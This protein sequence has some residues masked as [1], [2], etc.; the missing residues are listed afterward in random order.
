MT[1]SS[2]PGDP[3]P[4]GRATSGRAAAS[5]RPEGRAEGRR[6][7]SG[8]ATVPGSLGD[9][10]GADS[11]EA[12]RR[13]GRRPGSRTSDAG[14]L[15][16]RDADGGYGD[17]GYGA[18]GRRAG[19]PDGGYGR[20][21]A[22][23]GPDRAGGASRDG[24]RRPGWGRILGILAL[25][26]VVLAG[27]VVVGAGIW[28]VRLD[29]KVDRIPG[30]FDGLADR[31][32]ASADGV[33][34]IL[35]VGSDARAEARLTGAGGDRTKVGAQG[36]RADSIMIL[37]LPADRSSATVVSL[38]RDTWV[39][40]PGRGRGKLNAAYTAGPTRLVATVEGF[41]GTRID[42]FMVVDFTGFQKMTD[43]VGGVDFEVTQTVRSIHG[44]KILY[45][46]GMRH[47]TGVEALDYVRQRYG[48]ARGDFDRIA[49]QQRFIAALLGKALA[50]KRHPFRLAAFATALTEAVSVDEEFSGGEMRGLAWGMRGLDRAAVAF[51]TAPTRGTGTEGG[52]SV[53]YLQ[54][55]KA[56]A[57]FTAMRGNGAL[58]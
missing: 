19:S 6:S 47:F 43:A 2:V 53:V 39:P 20:S 58:P 8:R 13:D 25:V 24:R 29:G 49:N 52:E 14:Y 5:A 18:D 9:G 3:G 4:R 34:N 54:R 12:R 11:R 26:L 21:S 7:F 44:K 27:S 56:L 23:R 17:G 10:R 38:P 28:L 51:R 50:S 40:I 57:L 48:L 22:R 41:T 36:Q 37:H 42:H 16:D 32:A 35:M 46:K 55:D 45:E 31:P 15:G 1:R 33:L 30:V